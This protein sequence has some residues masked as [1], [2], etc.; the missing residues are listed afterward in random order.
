MVS[1][2]EKNLFYQKL[3]F[4]KS[5]NSQIASREEGRFLWYERTPANHRRVFQT[6][7]RRFATHP[8][9]RRK[10][11]GHNCARETWKTLAKLD[12]LDRIWTL[13]IVSNIKAGK[14]DYHIRTFL[15]KNNVFFNEDFILRTNK[16]HL[17]PSACWCR[18]KETIRQY[19][20][21]E[22]G[23]CVTVA[24]HRLDNSSASSVTA[25]HHHHRH[26]HLWKL[27]SIICDNPATSH[28]AESRHEEKMVA[29]QLSSVTGTGKNKWRSFKKK[30][31]INPCEILL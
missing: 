11:F 31:F 3:Q 29:P 18:R 4:F 17:M 5:A 21:R 23:G 25:H 26:H 10:G 27:I 13:H 6:N 12:K 19:C 15:E 20:H 30:D 9:S 7:R 16:K 14:K 2:I 28:F 8:L 22:N 24:R 1:V